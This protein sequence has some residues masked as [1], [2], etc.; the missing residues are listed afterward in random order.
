[1]Q[2]KKNIANYLLF[3]LILFLL[4]FFIRFLSFYFLGDNI[5]LP[6][7]KN[8]I[9]ESIRLLDLDQNYK[10]NEIFSISMPLYSIWLCLPIL[11]EIL[12][13]I[14]VN[15]QNVNEYWIKNNDGRFLENIKFN[16]VVFEII[17]S[18]LQSIILFYLSLLIFRNYKISV[19]TSIISTFYP[20]SIFFSIAILTEN[21]FIFILLLSLTFFY[22]KNFIL[23]IIFAIL[24]ILIRP[25]FELIYPLIL[26]NFI[27]IY[28]GLDYLKLLKYSILYIFLYLLFMSPW[29]YFNFQKYDTFVR[30][31]PNTGLMLYAGNNPKNISGGAIYGKDFTLDDFD[32][33]IDDPIK[34][35]SKL[36]EEALNFIINNKL[37]FIKNFFLKVKRMF[38][39]KLNSEIYSSSYLNYLYQLS[40]IPIFILSLLSFLFLNKKNLIYLSPLILLTIYLIFVHSVTFSSIRYRYSIEFIFFILASYSLINIYELIKRKIKNN[41]HF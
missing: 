7:S 20:L 32:E 15:L 29:W 27:L 8:Y 24:S 13:N 5:Y 22:K 39:F 3:F 1:M 2:V 30:L 19:A 41:I 26:I 35:D 34:L 11:I 21:F 23:G 16:I 40:Y 18:S 17:I 28:H 6:D 25:T 36:K 12:I 10:I 14:E 31:H 33:Y 38:N 37:I 4:S 9:A